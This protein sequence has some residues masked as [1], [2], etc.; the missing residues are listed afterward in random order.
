MRVGVRV[1]VKVK[2]RIR[3]CDSTTSVSPAAFF[4]TGLP[5]TSPGFRARV[6]VRVRF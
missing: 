3:T 5:A 1:K 4:K 2:V 6:R